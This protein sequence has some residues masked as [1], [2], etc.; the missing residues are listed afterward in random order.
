MWGASVYL[1]LLFLAFVLLP[2]LASRGAGAAGA[3]PGDLCTVRYN[4]VSGRFSHPVRARGA[5]CRRMSMGRCGGSSRDRE[6]G[7]GQTPA[8]GVRGPS[9]TCSRRSW[10]ASSSR[11]WKTDKVSR[12]AHVSVRNRYTVF[13]CPED[14][15]RLASRRGADLMAKLERHLAKHVAAK[16]Y[17]VSGDISGVTDARPRSAGWATSASLA[18]RDAPVRRA[19]PGRSAASAG[20][21]AAPGALGPRDR[22]DCRPRCASRRGRAS[23]AGGG[24]PRSSRRRTPRNCGLARQTIVLKTGSREHEFTQGRV[25]VG[26]ARDVDFR[27]DDADVSRRHAV[28]YWSDGNIMVKDLGSTNGTMVNGYPVTSTVVRPADVVL[29]RGLPHHGGDQVEPADRRD[30]AHAGD[31]AAGGEVRLP[32]RPLPVH[33]Q[34]RPLEHPRA[35]HGRARR[36]AGSSGSA[37]GRRRGR[38]GA[39]AAARR[40]RPR[41]ERGVDPRGAEEPLP[42]GRA[43][44]TPSRRGR[45]RWPAALPTWTSSWTTP[46]SRRNTR[47]SR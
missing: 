29:D 43:R 34:G 23:P 8:I 6:R 12:R 41:G 36:P 38:R 26:R 40:P 3:V 17:E 7:R 19:S 44:P 15:D 9:C 1:I 11:R 27:I 45:T 18:E 13:L 5:P 30:G 32:D 24:P 42:A 21:S 33:L 4:R 2:I 10:P 25:I 16:R 37:G 46:S 22:V 39:A 35:A 47:C 20:G 14:Y 28:I 31:S